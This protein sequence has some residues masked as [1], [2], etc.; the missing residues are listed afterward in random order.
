MFAAVAESER[1]VIVERT[2]DGLAAA[3][4]AGKKLGRPL[5]KSAPLPERVAT[6]RVGDRAEQYHQATLAVAGLGSNDLQTLTFWK[7]QIA[8]IAEIQYGKG[9]TQL[10]EATFRVLRD[11][12]VSTADK[13]FKRVDS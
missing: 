1:A 2:L 8:S 6:L 13:Y 11:D 9:V 4:R 10:Y 7:L 12:T 3:R 5:G